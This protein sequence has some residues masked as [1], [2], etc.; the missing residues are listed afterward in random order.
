MI[1]YDD[2]WWKIPCQ[3]GGLEH[4]LKR[5]NSEIE[6]LQGRGWAIMHRTQRACTLRRGLETLELTL[7]EHE[8]PWR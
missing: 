8:F 1:R 5:F 2:G 6:T 4:A 7:L 3:W